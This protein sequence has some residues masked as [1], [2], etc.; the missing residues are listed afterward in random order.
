MVSGA[1]NTDVFV[2]GCGP[3]GLA[4]AIAAR[5]KG[6]A[7][8]AAD[9]ARPPIDK[10]C[11]EGLM[12]EG[13]AALEQLG[14]PIASADSF[15]L[16]GIRFTGCG[17]SV[18]APFPQGCGFGVRRT[19]LHRIL[20]ERAAELGVSIFWGARVQGSASGAISIDGR[21]VRTQWIVGADGQNS[22]MRRWAGLELRRQ[23]RRRFGFRR[24]FH[25]KS[26]T[27]DVEVL[28]GE[29]CQIFV[30]P[31]TSG[32][33]CAALISRHRHVRLIEELSFFPE[34]ADRLRNARPALSERGALTVN[35]RLRK[36][37]RGR[38]ALVGDASGSVDAVTGLGLSLAFQQA[39]CL[40][41]ALAKDDLAIY[42]VAHRRISRI[43]A[44]MARL[45]LHMDKSAS[46]RRRALQGLA[47]EPL[48]FS[49]LLALH[50]G[51]LPPSAFEARSV[52]S[53][54]WRLLRA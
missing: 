34:L 46:I 51:A 47:A 4:A 48:I 33:V 22:Q 2:A 31:V 24:H 15:P 52:L 30:A 50:V 44:F 23:P 19:T 21:P 25:I 18:R 42:Q 8:A 10:A 40:A 37:T 7:V 1:V 14:I 49:R 5:L 16:R 28:W 53:L 11:G 17:A 36:V 41:E 20:T 32:E 35:R 26:W 43:P 38:T 3:A 13:V 9:S 27:D 6:L 45:M 29:R 54:G 12:P 39:I